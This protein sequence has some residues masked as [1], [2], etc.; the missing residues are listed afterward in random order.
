MV[1]VYSIPLLT[2]TV[3]RRFRSIYGTACRG[4]NESE[5]LSVRVFQM[6]S[7]A[8]LE[9]AR[10]K[11]ARVSSRA[12]ISAR[13]LVRRS[14]KRTIIVGNLMFFHFCLIIFSLKSIFSEMAT[15]NSWHERLPILFWANE[16]TAA[17]GGRVKDFKRF[18]RDLQTDNLTSFHFYPIFFSQNTHF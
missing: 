15:K 1:P 17:G 18:P 6:V 13:M 12:I 10:T 5:T 11:R 7:R 3:I 2:C 14:T 8:V 4:F 9:R 16:F